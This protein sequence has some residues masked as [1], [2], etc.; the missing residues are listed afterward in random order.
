M[1]YLF[2]MSIVA[3]YVLL[4]AQRRSDQ[5]IL[6][7]SRLDAG[8]KVDFRPLY[9]DRE[10]SKESVQEMRS[11]ES[12]TRRDNMGDVRQ[13][14]VWDE[15]NGRIK[16]DSRVSREESSALR[17][18]ENRE[19]VDD[20]RD[21][22]M[23]NREN[24]RHDERS[25]RQNR[26]TLNERQ[27]QRRV[28]NFRDQDLSRASHSRDQDQRS[29]SNVREKDL[30]RVSQARDQD[31][32]VDNVR[33][34]NDEL[35][36]NR[37]RSIRDVRDNQRVRDSQREEKI[38]TL[39]QTRRGQNRREESSETRRE[40]SNRER[41]T[42]VR[43][44]VNYRNKFENK[45]NAKSDFGYRLSLINWTG[46]MTILWMCNK[47]QIRDKVRSFTQYITI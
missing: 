26:F 2:V 33:S 44:V 1:N 15:K 36:L 32:R 11:R 46:L 40:M 34:Q 3:G 35:N 12:W 24:D 16:S 23:Y 43:N 28:S 17:N 31:R 20:L 18:V 19:R 47:K 4:M 10:V 38:E 37:E 27:D 9:Y 14:R 8:S 42:R 21:T 41:D 22:R 30:T 29:L 45:A 7:N 25:S 39:W 5:R 6:N 13:S